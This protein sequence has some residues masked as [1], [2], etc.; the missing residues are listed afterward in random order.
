MITEI[1][2][3]ESVNT[4]ALLIPPIPSA[5]ILFMYRVFGFNIQKTEK[6]GTNNRKNIGNVWFRLSPER[7]TFPLH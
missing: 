1:Q 2:L 5:R 3:F 4:K 6:Y 7:T